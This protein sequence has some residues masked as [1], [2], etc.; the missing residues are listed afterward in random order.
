MKH[1]V[2]L[3]PIHNITNLL[4]KII[5]YIM[6]FDSTNEVKTVSAKQQFQSGETHWI[7]IALFAI[8]N[9][10]LRYTTQLYNMLYVYLREIQKYCLFNIQKH[11]HHSH[12]MKIFKNS[13]TYL[14]TN[15][16]WLTLL[17]FISNVYLFIL[18]SASSTAKLHSNYQNYMDYGGIMCSIFLDLYDSYFNVKTCIL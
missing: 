10:P 2:D 5:L 18:I 11:T 14:Y 3:L 16:V 6:Y 13:Q 7:S 8:F 15:I 17:I 12:H 4:L 1:N 9:K